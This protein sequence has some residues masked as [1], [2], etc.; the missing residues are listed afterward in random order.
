M[1]GNAAFSEQAISTEGLPFPNVRVFVSAPAG[2]TAAIGTVQIN[3]IMLPTPVALTAILSSSF[4]VNQF[5]VPGVS[6]TGEIGTPSVQELN[7]S[8]VEGLALVGQVLV[9]GA[10]IDPV[11]TTWSTIDPNTVTSYSDITPTPGTTWTNVGGM[12]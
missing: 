2:M 5:V 11:D 10:I 4:A 6:A 9:W 1:L 12:N 3:E 8:G 7:V